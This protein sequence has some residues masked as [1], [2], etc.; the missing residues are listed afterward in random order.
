MNFFNKV[1]SFFT[2]SS[3]SSSFSIL[4]YKE[5]K[6]FFKS[7]VWNSILLHLFNLK[8][9][10]FVGLFMHQIFY[11][12]YKVEKNFYFSLR[13]FIW[14]LFLKNKWKYEKI[15]EKFIFFFRWK[16]F[17]D[18]FYDFPETCSLFHI[19]LF[20][21]HF[22][23]SSSSSLSWIKRCPLN[24]DIALLVKKEIERKSFHLEK[25][26]FLFQFSTFNLKKKGSFFRSF[27][28]TRTCSP[29]FI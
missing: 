8:L 2:F 17:K 12:E 4:F 18:L 10:I 27:C 24:Y 13:Y 16:T 25:F 6:Q 14:W 23:I 19:L 5:C 22:F 26:L 29:N 3:S 28:R 11:N 9:H 15:Y 21:F 7:F 1:K 20:H